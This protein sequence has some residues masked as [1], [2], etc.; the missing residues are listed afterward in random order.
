MGATLVAE[1]ARL[2]RRRASGGLGMRSIPEYDADLH[3][4]ARKMR[5]ARRTF[6]RMPNRDDHNHRDRLAR[7]A[8]QAMLDRGLLPDYSA[9]EMAEVTAIPGPARPTPAEAVQDLRGL[10][11]CSID[12]DDS[13]DLDQLTDRRADG[14]R[15][16]P[17]PGGDRGRRRLGATGLRDRRPRGAQ[18][19]LGVH[20]RRASSRCCRSACPRI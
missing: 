14:R 15:P 7:I 2:A 5:D 9:R 6:V 3:G 12:N 17:R 8:H 1:P 4:P 19:D 10:L 13:Q 16:R 11:W 18:H 20:R